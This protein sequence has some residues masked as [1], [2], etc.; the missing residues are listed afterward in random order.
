MHIL[1][2]AAAIKCRTSAEA[3]GAVKARPSV[4]APGATAVQAH[5][6]RLVPLSDFVLLVCF[7]TP[8]AA[9]PRPVFPLSGVPASSGCMSA[10]GVSSFLILASLALPCGSRRA[11]DWDLSAGFIMYLL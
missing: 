5:P 1:S 6:Q 9:V 4:R 3:F 2:V 10:L 7:R 11:P 8:S